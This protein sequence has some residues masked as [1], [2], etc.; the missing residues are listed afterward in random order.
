VGGVSSRRAWLPFDNLRSR[1]FTISL[2][3]QVL[4]GLILYAGLSPVTRSGFENI[5][6]TMRDSVLRFFI[7]EHLFGMVVA[8]ALAHVGRARVRKASD[9]AVRHRTVLVFVGLGMCARRLSL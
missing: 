1:F 3:V 6:L 8:V 7:V 5:G 4:I 9:P 2:D